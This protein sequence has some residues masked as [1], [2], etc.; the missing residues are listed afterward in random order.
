[1]DIARLLSPIVV[2]QPSCPHTELGATD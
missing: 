2:T 1:M